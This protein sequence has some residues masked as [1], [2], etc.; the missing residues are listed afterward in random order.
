MMVVK[1]K[2]LG[3]CKGFMVALF[4]PQRLPQYGDH[5]LYVFFLQLGAER[6]GHGGIP[7]PFR[8]REVTFLVSE[9][10]SVIGMQMHR[11]VVNPGANVLSLEVFQELVAAL[12]ALRLVRQSRVQVPCMPRARLSAH[13]AMHGTA[14]H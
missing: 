2:T 14:R 3:C 12:H 13:M 7:D 4:L 8:V 5:I 9:R 11:R 10:L 1:N 6:Q